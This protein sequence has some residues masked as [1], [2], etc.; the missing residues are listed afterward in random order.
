MTEC[1]IF[2]ASPLILLGKAG[3]L[4]WLPK[5]GH[6]KIPASVAEEVAAGGKDDA[7]ACWLRE[8]GA[9][10]ITPDDAVPPLLATWN[11]GAGETAVIATALQNSGAEGILDDAAARR[12]AAAHGIH[13]RGTISLVALAMRRGLIAEC[14]PVFIRLQSAGLFVTRRLL[15][16][17]LTATGEAPL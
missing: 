13:V 6:L 7:A 8:E 1:R 5:L 9:P 17:V 3:E 16:Q 11:L 2:N 14:R 12:C 10:F 4:A 15:N